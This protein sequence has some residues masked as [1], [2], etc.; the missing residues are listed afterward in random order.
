AV[1]F[2]VFVPI[3]AALAAVLTVLTFSIEGAFYGLMGWPHVIENAAFHSDTFSW[4]LALLEAWLTGSVW[5][6]GGGMIAAGWYR[7]GWLGALLTI[8]GLL[9][10]ILSAGALG[11]RGTPLAVVGGL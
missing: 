7:N 10:S 5:V 11:D 2:M 1:R 8:L 4:P 9:I 3:Y 6:A